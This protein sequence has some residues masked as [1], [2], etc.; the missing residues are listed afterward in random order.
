MSMDSI[1]KK[2]SPLKK[3]QFA[4]RGFKVRKDADG[5]YRVHSRIDG[6]PGFITKEDKLDG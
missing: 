6:K 4:K 3:T 1:T 5:A 2:R